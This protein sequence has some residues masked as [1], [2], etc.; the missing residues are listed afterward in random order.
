M[1]TSATPSVK[2]P[3]EFRQEFRLGLVVY[4]GVSLAIYMNGVCREFYNAVRGRGIYKLLKALTD[5]DLIVD[6]ISGTSAGGINGVLLSYALTNSSEDVAVDFKN[7]AEIWR[8]SGDIERLLRQP[9]P[10]QTVNSVLDGEGYYQ[11]RLAEAFAKAWEKR[12]RNPQKDQSEWFSESSELDLFVTGTDTL[13]KVYKAFD[14]TGCVIEIKD[15]RSVF[16]LKY[17]RDRKHPFQPPEQST[18]PQTA[19]AKLCRITSCFPVA[20]PVV[21]VQLE[22]SELEGISKAELDLI[23]KNP[24]HAKYKDYFAYAVDKHLM[25]WGQLSNRE[26]PPEK[27]TQT[28]HHQLHFVDGGVLDNRP[29]GYT[30]REIYHRTAYRPVERRLFYIDPSPD[31]FLGSAKF[32][33]MAKPTIWETVADSLVSMP[34]YE[35]IANDLQEIKE[36]NERVMRYKFLRSTA[37]RVGE[38]RLKADREKAEQTQTQLGSLDAL[39]PIEQPGAT[40]T[41]SVPTP[42]EIYLRCRLVGMRDRILPLILNIDQVGSSQ[43]SNA[44]PT[45]NQS[46]QDLLESAAQIITRYITDQKVKQ[47]R[48]K[49]LHDLGGEIR[50]LDVNYALRKHFF[51][52][53]KICQ[54]MAEPEYQDPQKD[55][56]RHDNLKHLAG[57][58]SRQVELLEVVQNSL[59]G[60][61]QSEPV[62]RTFYAL[63]NQAKQKAMAVRETTRGAAT[64]QIG[65]VRKDARRSIYDY[66]LR[67]HRFLLDSNGL[68]DFDP[69]RDL[70]DRAYAVD[71]PLDKEQPVKVP[72][73]FF[74]DLPRPCSPAEIS[75]VLLQLKQKAKLLDFKQLGL[76]PAAEVGKDDGLNLEQE[77]SLWQ[78]DRYKF[79]EGSEND[80]A[81]YYSLLRKI[82]LASEALIRE[83]G[84][85]LADELLLSFQSFRYI[86]QEVYA[87]EYLSDIQAK[88]QIEIIRISPDVAQFGFGKGKGLEDKLSGDQ[89]NAFGG[90]FKK[91]WRSNDIL[92]GRLDGLNRIIEALLTS[93]TLGNFSNF[94]SRQLDEIPGATVQEKTRTYLEN[95]VDEALPEALPTERSKIL[96][97]LT[98][99]AH[100][101]TLAGEALQQFLDT[102]VTAGQR[103]ILKTDLGNVFEDAITEQ[104]GWNQQLVPSDRNL[105][106]TLAKLERPTLTGKPPAAVNNFASFGRQQVA[107]QEVTDLVNRLLSPRSRK[108]R[109]LN[110]DT[111]NSWFRD[112]F[113][114]STSEDREKLSYYPLKATMGQASIDELA[115]FLKR[116]LAAGRYE[117]QRADLD[118][119]VKQSIAQLNKHLKTVLP[120]LKPKYQPVSGYF[121]RTITPFA[122]QELVATPIQELLNDPRQIDDYFRNVY[123]IGSETLSKD[124]P[125]VIL[126]DLA[127]RAGLVLR[128]IVNSPPTGPFVRKTTTFQVINRLLQGFYLWVQAKKPAS[129]LPQL[130]KNWLSLL[131][132]LV[133]VLSV[134]YII[135]KLPVWLLVLLITLFV[136]QALNKAVSRAKLPGWVGW[137]AAIAVV[138][139][140]VAGLRFWPGGASVIKTPFG[141]LRVLIQNLTR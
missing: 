104:I 53:E 72:I 64:E 92:W 123:R 43:A 114:Q 45:G 65:E 125:P 11:D 86:D 40:D 77:D 136:L 103:A 89:L 63:L 19:L 18:V 87:Y 51:L 62:S 22:N 47:D 10:H 38:A 21:T 68:I 52:L 102:I 46:K 6:V 1:N 2:K 49:F 83:R 140:V 8:E 27:N 84:G 50:N 5:S 135:S 138:G 110:Q 100:G 134:A 67:L 55:P 129:L 133:A 128:D 115:N 108:M 58:I 37:E 81:T 7:F 137:V 28:G 57:G 105:P 119:E 4:G 96:E 76:E 34:R 24:N 127:A 44:Q 82:E 93:T 116:L 20:F 131:L 30:I 74:E 66:L 33:K 126:E 23:L 99:L 32:N 97:H 73:D 12:D 91:S 69:E 14:N 94:V 36:R 39:E 60:M 121:D 139:L 106:K 101:E 113:S 117:I 132:L 25:R 70:K 15:H 42:Q 95:L 29:F 56:D 124:L 109:N 59:E 88:E 78:N 9:N 41:E 107:V 61:L 13:G 141:E 111:L 79:V 75:S 130:L 48:D 17:R 118:P 90:F 31:Q 71:E 3:K 112:A 35:S 26:L 120:Q 16:L 122:V 54:M 98:V 80:T 85:T